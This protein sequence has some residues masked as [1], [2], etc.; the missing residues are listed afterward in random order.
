MNWRSSSRGMLKSSLSIGMN[1]WAGNMWQSDLFFW[2]EECFTS[3]WL[4]ASNQS[5]LAFLDLHVAF[6]YRCSVELREAWWVAV[7][8]HQCCAAL[9]IWFYH[10][11]AHL[12]GICV[13]L[14]RARMWMF[15]RLIFLMAQNLT[16]LIEFSPGFS[17]RI[18][19]VVYFARWKS[20]NHG[21][22]SIPK[23]ALFVLLGDTCIGANMMEKWRS[24]G[25]RSEWVGGG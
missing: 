11:W 13:R 10:M 23:F 7:G 8:L 14:I 22:K 15:R 16:D 2:L 9:E 5:G 4:F 17:Q 1:V 21:V 20:R 24:R 19:H 18:F 3:V 6:P 25:V 12:C